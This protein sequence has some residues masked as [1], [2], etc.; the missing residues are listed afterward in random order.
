MTRQF[1]IYFDEVTKICNESSFFLTR[2]SCKKNYTG[3]TNLTN[4]LEIGIK[5]NRP[6]NNILWRSI[7]ELIWL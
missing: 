2:A 3:L 7:I 6:L 1:F 4:V 5:L